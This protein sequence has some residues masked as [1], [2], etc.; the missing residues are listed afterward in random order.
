MMC[1]LKIQQTEP[2][3]TMNI[4]VSN[5]KK[6]S[7]SQSG[8]LFYSASHHQIQYSVALGM[9]SKVSSS[10]GSVR[11]ELMVRCEGGEK[12]RKPGRLAGCINWSIH[13]IWIVWQIFWWHIPLFEVLQLCIYIIIYIFD[14]E[15]IYIYNMYR[16]IYIYVYPCLGPIKQTIHIC[17]RWFLMSFSFSW[18][19]SPPGP[20]SKR[21]SI[22]AACVLRTNLIMTSPPNPLLMDVTT[23]LTWPF[24][25]KE[26]KASKLMQWIVLP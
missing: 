12:I 9:P 20:N 6:G 10:S 1:S 7:P 24:N 11:G 26:M 21:W 14:K 22:T 4:A 8:V 3:N 5:K 13:K 25:Q 2:K 23:C 16:Y 18:I 15:M 17:A 19:L